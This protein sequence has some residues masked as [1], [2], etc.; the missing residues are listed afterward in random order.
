MAWFIGLMSGTSLDGVDGVLACRIDNG[1]IRDALFGAQV[2]MHGRVPHRPAVSRV[3]PQTH[4][5]PVDDQ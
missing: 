3:K 4:D 5:P 1:T 2:D